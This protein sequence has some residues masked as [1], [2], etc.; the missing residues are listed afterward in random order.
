MWQPVGG[1]FRGEWFYVYVW[2]SPFTVHLKLSQHC[3]S[4]ILQYKIKSLK[5]EEKKIAP[6]VCISRLTFSVASIFTFDS[7]VSELYSLL[8]LL[9]CISEVY[10]LNK[11]AS[12]EKKKS[13][14]L[15]NSYLNGRVPRIYC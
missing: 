3:K 11:R 1:E 2:L 6:N 8:I 5:L 13:M 15:I 9:L 14:C 10:L 7:A 12:W 4:A